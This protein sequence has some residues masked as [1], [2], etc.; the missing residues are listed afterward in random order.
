MTWK[1]VI[2]PCAQIG[3]VEVYFRRL[4][5]VRKANQQPPAKQPRIYL[6]L[7]PLIQYMMNVYV[8]Q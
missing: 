2:W 3:N 7:K 5:V 6:M 1:A 4:E 8:S